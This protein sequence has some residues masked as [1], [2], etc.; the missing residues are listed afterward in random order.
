MAT[1]LSADVVEKIYQLYCMNCDID[2]A[3]ELIEISSSTIRRYYTTFRKIKDGEEIT[4]K[5][6]NH[7][8]LDA[9]AEKH[10]FTIIWASD[11]VE[12]EEKKQEN[13]V[14][15]PKVPAN[16]IAETLVSIRNIMN[17]M[18]K[19]MKSMSEAWGAKAEEG[20]IENGNAN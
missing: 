1:Y 16:D 18:L 2:K 7:R 12:P 15:N 9:F 8:S 10:G 11:P 5:F 3:S 19:Y 14:K 4:C 20:G 6:L 17:Y 13:P